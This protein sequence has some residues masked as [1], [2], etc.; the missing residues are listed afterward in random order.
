MQRIGQR[1]DWGRETTVTE[2]R[3]NESWFKPSHG[4]NEDLRAK[5]GQSQEPT[6]NHWDWS[7]WIEGVEERES[8]RLAPGWTC[9]TESRMVYK[10]WSSRAQVSICLT[11]YP[12]SH[13]LAV[14]SAPNSLTFYLP[15]NEH[16]NS[17]FPKGHECSLI[18][19][20][21]NHGAW[22][23]GNTPYM[24]ANLDDFDDDGSEWNRDLQK[25]F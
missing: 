24:F 23:I 18:H 1:G 5:N 4:E 12:S 15:V 21:T 8:E 13:F 17:T 19:V 20:N 14:R 16:S 10:W 3:V 2:E 9:M 22:H 25:M 6:P 11:L 7:N